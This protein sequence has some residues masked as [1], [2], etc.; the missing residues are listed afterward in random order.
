M[1]A[2]FQSEDKLYG[3]LAAFIQIRSWESSDSQTFAAI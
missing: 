1:E 2:F 3:Q